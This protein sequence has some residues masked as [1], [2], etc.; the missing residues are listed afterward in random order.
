MGGG[1]TETGDG[2]GPRDIAG[3]MSLKMG[4]KVVDYRYIPDAKEDRG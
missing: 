3:V 1:K 2:E 4:R